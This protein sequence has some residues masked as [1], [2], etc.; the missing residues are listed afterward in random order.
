MVE[1]ITRLRGV[2]CA[3]RELDFCVRGVSYLKK[4]EIPRDFGSQNSAQALQT[5]QL[6]SGSVGCTPEH[7]EPPSLP[8]RQCVWVW[9]DKGHEVHSLPTDDAGAER[10]WVLTQGGQGG[11]PPEAGQDTPPGY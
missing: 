6:P 11:I 10:M 8:G 1:Q 4:S 7:A 9:H 2:L 3:R 5:P